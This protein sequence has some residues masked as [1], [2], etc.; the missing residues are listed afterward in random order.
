VPRFFRS[1][2]HPNR[3]TDALYNNRNVGEDE[4]LFIQAKNELARI[5]KEEVLLQALEVAIGTG[6]ARVI[7][8]TTLSLDRFIPHITLCL[9]FMNGMLTGRN[10]S[11]RTD[12]DPK[13]WDHSTISTAG[14][15]DAI[16]EA[17]AFGVRTAAG[18][19][20]LTEG[21]YHRTRS[22]QHATHVRLLLAESC[23]VWWCDPHRPASSR[24]A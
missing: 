1:R 14:L 19:K 13:E 10:S 21:I 7:S 22:A 18:K 24:P 17:N 23:M 16:R 3:N 8:T 20:R 12:S 11:P 4:P 9:E 2:S 15:E 5:E 6:A